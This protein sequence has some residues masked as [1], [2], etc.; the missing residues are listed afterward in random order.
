MAVCL[1]ERALVISFRARWST[2]VFALRT[3]VMGSGIAHNT[4][5]MSLTVVS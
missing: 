3:S 5:R 2:S 1:Q 4:A